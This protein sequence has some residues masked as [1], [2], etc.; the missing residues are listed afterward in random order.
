MTASIW[1][2]KPHREDLYADCLDHWGAPAQTDMLVEELAELIVAVQKYTK[3]KATYDNFDHMAEEMA[4]VI[5][6]IEEMAFHFN[7][8]GHAEANKPFTE[9][10][11]G[12]M[13]FKCNRTE[14]RLAESIARRYPEIE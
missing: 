1:A 11:A 8:E 5:L 6:M 12:W 4:D 3:R 14:Q 7:Q 2:S 13:A 9:M 10:V